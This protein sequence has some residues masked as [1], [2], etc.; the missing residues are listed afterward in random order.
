MILK[1][2]SA[3]LNSTLNKDSGYLPLSTEDTNRLLSILP[4]GD[5][6]C[7]T[8]MDNLYVE[9]IR[10]E[11]Q[12]GVIVIERGIRGSEPRKFPRGT[13]VLF[14]MSLPLIEWLICNHDC[15]DGPCPCEP[16]ESAGVIFPPITVDV[17]WEGTAIFKGDIPMVFAVTGMPSWMVAEYGANYVKFSGTPTSDYDFTVSIAATNCSGSAITTQQA[18]HNKDIDDTIEPPIG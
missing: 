5:E 15:C 14:E 2:F 10:A 13:C 4:E 11:N 16:V 18:S 9:W 8:L 6:M 3:T 7:L 17:P 12:C 1:P